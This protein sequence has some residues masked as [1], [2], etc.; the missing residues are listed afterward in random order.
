MRREESRQRHNHI[1]GDPEG[2][3]DELDK[4]EGCTLLLAA[5]R[6]ILSPMPSMDP[7]CNLPGRIKT[8]ILRLRAGEAAT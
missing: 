4:D 7:R 2:D 5:P 6:L 3:E 1:R 8:R